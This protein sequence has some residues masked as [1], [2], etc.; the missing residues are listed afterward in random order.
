M[1]CFPGGIASSLPKHPLRR[2]AAGYC[3]R[4]ESHPESQNNDVVGGSRVCLHLR[5]PLNLVNALARFL[6]EHGKCYSFDSRGSGYG[7]G[8][9]VASILIKPL[10][11]A[12]AHG[13]PIRAIIRNTVLNQDG[14]TP[15]LTMPSREAQEALIREAYGN[16]RL[17]PLDTHYVEAHGTGTKAGDPIEVEAIASLL[18]RSRSPSRPL[19]IGS[20]KANIGHLESASGLAGLI[21]AVLCLEKGQIPPSIN[22]ETENANLHLQEKC[23]RVSLRDSTSALRLIHSRLQESSS[24]GLVTLCAV[25]PSTALAMVEPT[26]MLY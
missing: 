26:H 18:S 25:H 3:G 7:R 6:S 4:Y 5:W 2:I 14:K 12:I 10:K 24:H 9:G 21:K 19:V 11:D 8:E 20:V 1:F 17:D 23:M 13:D 15:G 16:A 22:F